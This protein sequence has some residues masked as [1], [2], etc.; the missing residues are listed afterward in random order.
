MEVT[1]PAV[2]VKVAE[3]CP[4]GTVTEPGT[5]KEP[6][7]E[8]RLTTAP[9]DPAAA[10]SAAVQV[11]DPADASEAG[12]QTTELMVAGGGPE[13]TVR[14][15]PVVETVSGSP[16]ALTPTPLVTAIEE[17]AAVAVSCAVTTPT[18]PFAIVWEFEP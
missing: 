18:T 9:P 12:L 2:A 7:F 1:A 14:V 8:L 4:A 5:V 17:F 6:R 16:A 10:L 11:A 13:E 3:V 15:P